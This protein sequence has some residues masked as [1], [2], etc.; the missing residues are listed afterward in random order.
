M[1]SSTSTSD[2]GIDM[3]L[4]SADP[5]K[6]GA[7]VRYR[8]EWRHRTT[9]ELL[10]RRD[11]EGFRTEENPDQTGVEPVFE[12]ITTYR[13]RVL[14]NTGPGSQGGPSEAPVLV[15]TMLSKPEYHLNIYSPAIANALHSVVKYYPSQSLSGDPIVIRWPYPILV[16]HYDEL[17]AFKD[18][19][20]KKDPAELCIM[21]KD[22]PEHIKLLLAF[23]DRHVMDDV[24]AEQE[25]LRKGTYTWEHMWVGYKPGVTTIEKFLGD[26]EW[27][28]RVVHG[29][30]GGSFETDGIVPWSITGWFMT[31]D[32]NEIGRQFHTLN[33]LKFD[34]ESSSKVYFIEHSQ[35][36]EEKLDGLPEP[37]KERIKHGEAW[38]NLLRKQ[39]KQ[40]KGKTKDFPYNEVEGL[41][42][43][44]P[45]GY[46][47]NREG[48]APPSF[49]GSS[50]CRPSL[51]D[52]TCAFCK[53]HAKIRTNSEGGAAKNGIVALYGDYNDITLEDYDQLTVHQYLLCPIEIQG[54]VFK[55]RKWER[56]FVWNFS[57]AEW[58]EGMID[59]LVMDAGRKKTLMSLSKS[60]AR[61][62]K[63]GE[64]M[65]KRMWSADFVK[66]KGSG[67]IFLLHGRPGVGKTCTAECIAAF[68]R[69]PLMVLT[70]SDIGTRPSEVETNL[71]RM[72]K[73]AMSWDAVLL[74]DEADVF[75]ER[76]TTADLE[77]N[78]LVAGFLRALEFYDGILFLTTNRVGAFDDAFI[79]RVHVQ[80]Y[81]PEF[82][83]EQ[84]QLVWKTFTDKLARER[85]NYIRLNIDAKEYIRGAEMRA[86]E[87]NGREIRNA[88]QTAVA[89]AEYDAEKDEEGKILVTDIHLKAVVELSRDFKSY[90]HELHRG[91]EAKRAER[92]QE[93]L[94][95][96]VNTR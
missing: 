92:R 28:V 26:T 43:I 62:N 68:T 25:R 79:S 10:S 24:R 20:A 31:Y 50:D 52:G 33:G 57:E 83:D 67:L 5:P 23:L 76:R 30:S 96:D 17:V 45:K 91:S 39:C 6:R 47:M 1:E 84:R 21:E 3:T 36:D 54:F 80:L 58:D 61:R 2:S 82:T 38:F 63:D 12:L 56:L 95:H 18:A 29:V 59:G 78:S 37:A 70:S 51:A 53:D 60:F 75:M 16:H 72:F 44:D 77:R 93:R 94:E 9:D 90:L 87:W 11:T 8:T 41:V 89:L 71:T 27:T 34:G 4:S 15:T 49:I 14:E 42:M 46:Y 86:V 88:L 73:T 69:R 19:A 55:T 35:F 74:I 81:F 32:G 64:Q 85:G 48:D 66:G 40:H 65:S 13:T 7:W 22:A